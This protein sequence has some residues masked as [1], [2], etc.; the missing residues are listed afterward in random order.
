VSRAPL[1]VCVSAGVVNAADLDAIHDARAVLRPVRF[2]F[3][4]LVVDQ[5]GVE[6][7]GAAW[8]S[9]ATASLRTEW[10]RHVVERPAS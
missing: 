6:L 9:T 1:I 3:D 8:R 4:G 10:R 2:D 7:R 5:L